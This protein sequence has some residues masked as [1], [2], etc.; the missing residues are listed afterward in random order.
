VLAAVATY[1]FSRIAR[2]V[3]GGSRVSWADRPPTGL[4][5]IKVNDP[6]QVR[7]DITHL[8]PPIAVDHLADGTIKESSVALTEGARPVGPRACCHLVDPP[9]PRS[10]NMVRHYVL[11]RYAGLPP[12]DAHYSPA[13]EPLGEDSHVPPRAPTV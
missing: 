13:F 3:W 12:C 8:P 6:Q 5:Q 11:S 9:G 4:K 2:R 1:P 10:F 7:P